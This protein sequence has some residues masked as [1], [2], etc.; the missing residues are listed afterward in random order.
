VGGKLG[1]KRKAHKPP[2]MEGGGENH[3]QIPRKN[4]ARRE[5]STKS[6]LTSAPMEGAGKTLLRRRR[7]AE[8]Q[9]FPGGKKRGEPSTSMT[10]ANSKLLE[11]R[12][13]QVAVPPPKEG[14]REGKRRKTTTQINRGGREKRSY[15]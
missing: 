13:C 4:E 9:Y 12:G 14:E 5:A 6:L 8:A 1:G 2:S 10:T 11:R 15:T 3:L 7:K